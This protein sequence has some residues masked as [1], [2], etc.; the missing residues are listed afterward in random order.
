MERACR[1]EVVDYNP[2]NQVGVARTSDRLGVADIRETFLAGAGR[3]RI[4]RCGE[5]KLGSKLQLKDL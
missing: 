2:P 4:G 5:G 3:V 1:V